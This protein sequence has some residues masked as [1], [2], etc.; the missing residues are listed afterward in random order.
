MFQDVSGVLDALHQ[1]SV[2]LSDETYQL[3]VDCLW[4]FLQQFDFVLLLLM[5]LKDRL[6]PALL[7]QL[8]DAALW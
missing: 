6:L 7:E 4:N 3:I 2:E 1:D 5:L 8:K